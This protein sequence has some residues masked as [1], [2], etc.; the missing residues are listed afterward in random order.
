MTQIPVNASDAITIQKLQGMTKDAVIVSSWKYMDANK[1][2]V[3]LSRVRTLAGLYLLRPLLK[4]LSAFRP[5]KDY[6]EFMKGMK[7]KEDRELKRIRK[8]QK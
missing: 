4:K 2:Y 7:V 3:V 1:I 6:L 5:S 8:H